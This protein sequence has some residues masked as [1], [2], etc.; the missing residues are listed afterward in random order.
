MKRIAVIIV[1]LLVVC[2]L[3]VANAQTGKRSKAGEG[4]FEIGQVAPEIQGKDLDSKPM[5]LGEFRGKVVVLDFWGF[6]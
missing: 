6:W 2:A 1:S 4:G 3:D 5:K